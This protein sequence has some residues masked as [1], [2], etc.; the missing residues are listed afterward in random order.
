[1]ENLNIVVDEMENLLSKI[2]FYNM[3]MGNDE[4]GLFPY[5]SLNAYYKR[6]SYNKLKG[7]IYEL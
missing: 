3:V 4:T 2:K 7:V 6:S 5:E 1:M